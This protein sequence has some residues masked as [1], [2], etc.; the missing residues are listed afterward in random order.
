MNFDGC[1][2]FSLP[3]RILHRHGWEKKVSF[4]HLQTAEIKIMMWHKTRSEAFDDFR[5]RVLK[6][7][8]CNSITHLMLLFMFIF[9]SFTLH[10][11]KKKARTE[12]ILC[13]TKQKD[14]DGITRW[15][16][17]RNVQ[18]HRPVFRPIKFTQ[19]K[20]KREKSMKVNLLKAKAM[21]Y[22]S[23]YMYSLFSANF[24]LRALTSFFICHPFFSFFFTKASNASH[25]KHI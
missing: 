18:R 21:F 8:S 16:I 1:S 9:L 24:I 5:F 13:T 19:K 15:G 14:Y 23:I 12:K 7:E 17:Q 2:H 25:I 4:F 3:L 22:D 11:W 20:A 6:C 10:R